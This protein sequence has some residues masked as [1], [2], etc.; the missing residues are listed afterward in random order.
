MLPLGWEK[1]SQ[2]KA[3][4]LWGDWNNCEVLAERL[5]AGLRE[6][7]ATSVSVIACPLPVA[8]GVCVAVRDRLL[9]AAQ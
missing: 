8:R 9:K 3:S 2:A 6:L 4:Y 5:F 1:P 7:D